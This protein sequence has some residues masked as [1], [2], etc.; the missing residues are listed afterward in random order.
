MLLDDLNHSVSVMAVKSSCA[1]SNYPKR[2]CGRDPL[3]DD[4]PFSMRALQ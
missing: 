2:D 3:D 1:C 4:L